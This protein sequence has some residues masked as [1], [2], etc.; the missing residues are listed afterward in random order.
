LERWA[1]MDKDTGAATVETL[2]QRTPA[3]EEEK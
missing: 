3:D 1:R 2:V